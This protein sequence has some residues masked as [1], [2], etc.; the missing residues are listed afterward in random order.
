MRLITILL[1]QTRTSSEEFDRIQKSSQQVLLDPDHVPHS[2]SCKAFRDWQRAASSLLPGSFAESSELR[3]VVGDEYSKQA[4]RF[5]RAG[6]LADQM[7][8]ARRLEEAFACLVDAGRTLA[9]P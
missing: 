5:G 4:C 1:E 8:A 6:V 2:S 3:A 9:A 7:F